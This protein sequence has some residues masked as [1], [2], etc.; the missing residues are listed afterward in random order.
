MTN[1]NDELLACPEHPTARPH[2]HYNGEK[3]CSVCGL[4]EY[5]FVAINYAPNATESP[6]PVDNFLQFTLPIML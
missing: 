6:D 4:A 1:S 5:D 2:R 3:W